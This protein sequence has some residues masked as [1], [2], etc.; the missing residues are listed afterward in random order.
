[1]APPFYAHSVCTARQNGGRKNKWIFRH[2]SKAS[3]KEPS[4]TER[5]RQRRPRLTLNSDDAMPAHP[6]CLRHRQCS[7][8]RFIRRAC[9][10]ST[11]CA[12]GYMKSS[13]PP[14]KTLWISRIGSREFPTQPEP[15]INTPQTALRKGFARLGR[16]LTAGTVP[17]VTNPD[18]HPSIART[19]RGPRCKVLKPWSTVEC[20]HAD[21]A[22]WTPCYQGA[23]TPSP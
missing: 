16:F 20:C 9:E 7:S 21:G 8:G 17:P 14:R 5:K 19:H 4:T 1:M 2:W 11:N 10:A 23:Q 12:R 3:R 15:R 22:Q 6:A 18:T 13:L